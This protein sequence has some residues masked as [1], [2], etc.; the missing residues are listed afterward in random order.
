[1]VV[2]VVVVNVLAFDVDVVWLVAGGVSFQ[3]VV[4]SAAFLLLQ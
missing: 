4:F 3:A 2:V 1:V